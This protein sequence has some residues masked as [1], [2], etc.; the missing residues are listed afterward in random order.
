ML[1]IIVDF[2]TR[3]LLGLQV[4]LR[5]YGY[6][7][8]LVLGFVTAIFLA[9]WRAKRAGENPEHVSRMGLLA[10]IGGILGARVAYIIQHPDSFRSVGSMLDVTSGGLIYYGGVI[11][12]TLV[13]LGYLFVKRLPVRRHLDI[14]AASL[15]IGLAFGRAGCTL[16]GCCY[17]A[18]VDEHWALG[19][20][21][22]MF[23]KPL[24][25]FDGRA[26]PYSVDTVAPTPAYQHQLSPEQAP[27]RR[28][29]PPEALVNH[30]DSRIKVGG[31]FQPIIVVHPPKYLH[32]ALKNDQTA[33]WADPNNQALARKAFLAAAGLDGLL[34]EREWQ[35]ALSDGTG[36]LRGGE[37][38]D[39]AACLSLGA[40][41][42]FQDV[43][44]YFSS[45]RQRFDADG[46]GRLASDERAAA[47][48]ELQAD[49]FALA[50][51]EHSLATKPA[52]VLA[53]L[54]ALLLAGLLSLYYRH[55][56]REGEVFALLA[57]LYPVTRFVEESIRADNPHDLLRGILTHNQYS[58][59][60]LVSI[61]IVFWLALRK[62]PA[63]CA[64]LKSRLRIAEI[65]AI[66]P[67]GGAGGR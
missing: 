62:L 16:N 67:D 35:Q 4:P 36:L 25:K 17:G 29:H 42:T 7:L 31:E 57:I 46:D 51:G 64:P 9:Q 15:M 10:L 55:R 23:S 40:S 39:E 58:S 33:M 37:H 5:I 43:W 32:G 21:F 52:Q 56:R 2:G 1:Q 28:V 44:S 14:V 11:L 27:S 26:N 34:D 12:A 45:L 50:G 59:L 60:A 61:G 30:R 6:G 18:T 8:M 20:H 19:M 49:Q 53:M 3:A 13:V 22:P 66:G 48:A 41:L 47:N 65:A 38:W 63:S 54:N 24:A